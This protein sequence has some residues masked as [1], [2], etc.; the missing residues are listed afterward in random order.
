[1]L[2]SIDNA[3]VLNIIY[4][5]YTNVDILLTLKMKKTFPC[6]ECYALEPHVAEG[7]KLIGD[8]I[9]NKFGYSGGIF[10]LVWGVEHKI[11]N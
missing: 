11:D 8:W 10:V 9:F 3:G 6:C 4:G 2:D 7:E 1:M 5:T